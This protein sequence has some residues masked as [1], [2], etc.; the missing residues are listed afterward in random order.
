M[1]RD[2]YMSSHKGNLSLELMTL[3]HLSL[4]LGW[5]RNSDALTT[6]QSARP[7]RD[8]TELFKELF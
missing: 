7:G 4:C 5:V 8:A 3:V 6:V 2:F 1:V